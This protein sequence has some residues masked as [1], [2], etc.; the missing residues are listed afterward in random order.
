MILLIND[1]TYKVNIY[2]VNI[3][4]VNFYKLRDYK[5]SVNR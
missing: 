4:K 5:Q 1:I 3:Y 2:K